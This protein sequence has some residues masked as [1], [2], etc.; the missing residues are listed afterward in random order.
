[1]FLDGGTGRGGDEFGQLVDGVLGTDEGS[2]QFPPAGVE[3]AELLL[4]FL[5]EL[6]PLEL[7]RH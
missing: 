6:E 4:F 7:V 2:Q 5:A 3:N 1:L